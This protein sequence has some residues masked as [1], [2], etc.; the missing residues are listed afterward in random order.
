MLGE[1]PDTGLELLFCQGVE[2]QVDP[3]AT[4]VQ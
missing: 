2:Y 4:C 3:F 1:A